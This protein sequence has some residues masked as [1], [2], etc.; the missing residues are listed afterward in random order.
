MRRA[1]EVDE[2]DGR[3]GDDDLAAVDDRHDTLRV[4]LPRRDRTSARPC[5]GAVPP[6]RARVCCDDDLRR[7][8]V[9]EHGADRI[10]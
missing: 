4:P 10:T 1:A 6:A 2:R 7:R 8:P 3:H 5:G 9:R